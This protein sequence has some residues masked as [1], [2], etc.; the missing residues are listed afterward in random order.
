[1]RATQATVRLGAIGHNLKTAITLAP[2][3]KVLPVIKANA[4]GHGVVEVAR[5]L[6]AFSASRVPAF[7]VAFMDEAVHLRQAG[8]E[9]PILVLQ[10]CSQPDDIAEAAAH[11]FWLMLHSPE[12]VEWVKRSTT[13]QPARLWLK[14]DTGMRR[15]GLDIADLG[16]ITSALKASENVQ[17]GTVLCSHLACADD[18]QNQQTQQQI[19]QL[20]QGAS[21]Y[22][23][24]W[25]IA[26]SAGI[27]GWPQSH[28]DWIR[29][30]YMLYGN[31]PLLTPSPVRLT[32]AM[33]MT[34]EI[35]AIRK[36]AA[37][38]AVGYGHDWVASAPTTIGILS[39]GYADGYPRHAP[40]GTPVWLNGQR[41][42]L[43]GRVSMDMIAIDLTGIEHAAVGDQVE[44]WGQNVNVD[45]VAGYA[46]TIGYEILAGLSG[47]VPIHY[48]P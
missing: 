11:D 26:N 24:P 3:S 32:A 12:Q 25:S 35:I 46:G 47:R 40:S 2:G 36:I 20:K 7:A 34:S 9:R 8:I 44:L 29:P 6:E 42:G 48:L 23:L 14:V 15:L 22:H 17:S 1:M 45:E 18:L 41:A 16:S 37:G 31:N 39:I 33:S 27:I 28:G 43:A 21:T 13:R 4:Y 10:G 30:G 38:Q 19:E 5:K